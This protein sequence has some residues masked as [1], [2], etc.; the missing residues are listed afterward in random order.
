MP[1][2]VDQVFSQALG[3][4]QAGRLAEAEQHYRAILQ[5]VPQHADS[6]HLLGVIALQK[7]R[8]GDALKLI[9]QACKLRP[10]GAVY[11]SNRGQVLERLERFDDAE[12]AYRMAIALEP[13]GAEA[14]NNL[15]RLLQSRGELE[16]A[17]AN[18]LKAI[19]LRPDYAEPHTNLGNLLKDRGD[20]DAAIEA[21]RRAV[22]LRPDLSLLHSN[23]LL[24]LHYHADVG[25]ED[26]KREHDQWAARHVEPLAA[27]R[28]PH[29]N[30][31]NPDRHIRVG[32]G[33]A[34]FCEHAVAR[35]ILP[36]LEN[37]DR[38][39]VELFGYSDVSRPDAVTA[40]LRSQFHHWRECGTWSD[41]QL[42]ARI[43]N[44]RVDILVDLAAHSARNRLLVFARKPAPVQVTYLAYCSTTG[45]DAIDYR[46]TDRFLDPVGDDETH[47]TEESIRLPHCYWCYSPPALDE[48]NLPASDRQPG[49]L[50]FGCLNN[51]AKVTDA[52]LGL[53][54]RLLE[55]VPEARL[56]IYARAEWHRN[57][58]R[59]ALQNRGLSEDRLEFLGWQSLEDYLE[60]YRRIDVALDP[61]P[62]TGGTTTCDALWMGVPVVTLAGRT[63][64]S[65]GG[66]SLL[67][68]V[69]LPELVARSE[70]EYLDIAAELIRDADRLAAL[71]GSLRAR[72]EASPVMDAPA[73]VGALEAAYGTMW[74]R[75]C[76]D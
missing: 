66:A 20:L 3:H 68:N 9:E 60:A 71:R 4:H 28:Q 30:V 69:G 37:H 51:F 64:V 53:W 18:F 32:Y 12:Q 6:L 59:A 21:F 73:F 54:A 31:P 75:W 63:A 74:R 14:F 42:A 52:T 62:Y 45:V 49:P 58:V 24:T 11:Q 19:E 17:E 50:T 16:E 5:H 23:L 39:E 22:E 57:R 44:D 38:T 26:L 29:P 25:P 35:F 36:I 46:L 43:R 61:M 55:R 33:S 1:P 2:T 48:D 27:K 10:D 47:Y 70:D 40:L 34:D 65:R 41:E 15:G 72:L 76:G 13:D 8:P 7:G 67:S 56:V